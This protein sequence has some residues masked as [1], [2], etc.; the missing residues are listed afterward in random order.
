MHHGKSIGKV[1]QAMSKLRGDKFINCSINFLCKL[2]IFILALAK[3]VQ[4]A[5]ESNDPPP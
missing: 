4:F 3:G 2:N 1:F 5:E